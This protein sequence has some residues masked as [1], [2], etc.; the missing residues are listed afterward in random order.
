M[1]HATLPPTLRAM[2]TTPMLQRAGQLAA[3]LLALIVLV[4]HADTWVARLGLLA[5]AVCVVF[6]TQ[7]RKQL[8]SIRR[9]SIE[10]PFQQKTNLRLTVRNRG[11]DAMFS[12]E[13]VVHDYVDSLMD[14]QRFVACWEES[15]N[16][17]I[18]IP[19]GA[20]RTI[21]LASIDLTDLDHFSHSMT[22]WKH[23][24]SGAVSALR[25]LGSP[26]ELELKKFTGRIILR[27]RPSMRRDVSILFDVAINDGRIQVP[28]WEDRTDIDVSSFDP[29]GRLVPFWERCDE[30]LASRG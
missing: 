12:A 3:L 24:A 11:R 17:E 26:Q 8:F 18:E 22:F 21:R 19:A 29:W 10:W 13:V 16:A 20:I 4:E 2:A 5:I 27:S 7:V 15:D 6:W 25:R 28:R 23:S 1:D 14:H 9:A 30:W